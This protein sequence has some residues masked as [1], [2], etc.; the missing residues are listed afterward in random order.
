MR[1][2][3]QKRTK[4]R[5]QKKPRNIQNKLTV[6]GTLPN[7]NLLLQCEC[8]L[9]FEQT[10]EKA[11]KIKE[12]F[13]C[14]FKVIDGKKDLFKQVQAPGLSKRDNRRSG[15]SGVQTYFNGLAKTRW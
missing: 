10:P 9:K 1:K 11:K 13:L 3:L 15:E 14:H 6:L 4:K 2:M 8:G 7:G 5:T 12:C